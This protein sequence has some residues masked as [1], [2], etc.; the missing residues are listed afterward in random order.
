MGR[1]VHLAED[2]G[3]RWL[4]IIR[5]NHQ[6]T[7]GAELLRLLGKIESFRGAIRPG[8][9]KDLGAALY[10]LDSELDDPEVF[11]DGKGSRFA[12]GANRNDPINTRGDL[13]L[14][15]T[16]QRGLIDAIVAEGSDECGISTPE[17]GR[18][19]WHK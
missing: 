17:A 7:V 15:Q 10:H 4:V 3:L 12:G 13:V 16:P 8:P 18:G 6:K 5:R 14:H 1:E 11:L 9:G 19:N 2:S